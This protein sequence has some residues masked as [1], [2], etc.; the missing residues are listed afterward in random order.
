MAVSWI[1]TCAG[2]RRRTSAGSEGAADLGESAAVVFN[3]DSTLG[4]FSSRCDSILDLLHSIALYFSS[5]QR[6]LNT[7]PRQALS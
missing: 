1:V 7:T 3:K 6:A 2:L 5:R 4:S